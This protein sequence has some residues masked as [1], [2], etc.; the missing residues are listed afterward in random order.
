MPSATFF[1]LPEEKR[2]KL[3]SAARQEFVRMPYESVS[4]N[5]IIQTAE[6]PRG[7]FYMYF[8][9]KEELFRYL[10]QGY[11]RT[12]AD[13]VIQALRE[14][15]GDPFRAA[16]AL[17]D[18]A[19]EHCLT[20]GRGEALNGLLQMTQVNCTL[21]PGLLGEAL[22]L[23]RFQQEIAAEVDASRLDIQREGDLQLMLQILA[24]MTASAIVSAVRCSRAAPEQQRARYQESL[25]ILRRGMAKGQCP[26]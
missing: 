15:E 24:K 1:N 17:Y 10:L 14:S 22:D 16:L 25:S 20:A 6:I 4:I 19:G 23:E 9:D 21:H 5:R 12:L 7:S 26:A 8:T 3:M 13:A 11:A 2:E 18:R